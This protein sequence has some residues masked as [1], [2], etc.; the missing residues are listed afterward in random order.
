MTVIVVL[1][2]LRPGVAAADY[3]AW[4]RNTDLP[5]VRNLASI[6]DF[7]VGRT[8]QRLGSDEP[9]PY[10]YVEVVKVKDMAQFGADVESETMQRVSTEFQHWA[11]DPVFMVTQSLE[12]QD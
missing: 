3:E 7:Y 11:D 9:A 2:N 12:G 5:I 10:A 1:F 6:A 4:A 8:V